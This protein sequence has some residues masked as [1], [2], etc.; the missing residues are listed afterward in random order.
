MMDWTKMV[1]ITGFARGGTS[2]L[3]DCVAFHPEITKIPSEIVAFREFSDRASIEKVV[4]ARITENSLSS[5]YYVNKAPANSPFIAMACSMFPESR[6]LFIIRDPRD[7]FVSHKRGRRAWMRGRNRTVDGCMEKMRGYYEGYLKARN[8]G[9]IMLVT[10]EQLHQDFHNTMRRI[11]GFIG[12]DFDDQLIEDCFE[13]N[14]FLAAAGRRSEDRDHPRRKGVVGDWVN[15]LKDKEKRWYQSDPFWSNFLVEHRYSLKPMTYESMLSAMTQAGAH[16]LDQDEI[17]NCS[18]RADKLNVCLFHDLD[19]LGR[20]K[21]RDSVLATAE[22]EASFGMACVFNLL[23]L[24][25]AN[26]R[27]YK[28]K[29]ILRLIEDIRRINPRASFGLHLN[30]AERFFPIKMAES[31]DQHPKMDKAVQY[32]HKQIDAYEKI[33]IRF[34]LSTAHG[35]GRGKKKPNNRDSPRFTKELRDRGITLWDNLIRK[36]LDLEATHV[37]ALHDVGEPIAVNRMPHAGRL[38]DPESYRAFPKGALIRFLTHPGNY[39]IRR[40]L[41][42]GLRS[43]QPARSRQK[44]LV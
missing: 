18:L 31:D 38:D 37:T 6:F 30:A 13:K 8:A 43:N 33:G 3:R 39:D 15:Y 14:T 7:V 40:P 25:D 9:N 4:L 29:D 23:P 2:W 17:L 41:V 1:F 26:Y 11:Y 35:Y 32:L 28:P 34:R 44:A 5:R 12:V 21:N 36:K 19:E 10:Y 20:R 16:T 42:L 22:I 27:G 24:D